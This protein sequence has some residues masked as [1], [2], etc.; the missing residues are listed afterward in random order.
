MYL[1]LQVSGWYM[2]CRSNLVGQDDEIL[3]I[4]QHTRDVSINEQ[5]RYMIHICTCIPQNVMC[6]IQLYRSQIISTYW[7]DIVRIK[8]HQ[9]LMI[10]E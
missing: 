5:I 8:L 6:L 9:P 4:P 10:F 7:N 3:Y 2:K 1:H